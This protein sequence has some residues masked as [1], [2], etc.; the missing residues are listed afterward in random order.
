MVTGCLVSC[1]TATFSPLARTKE[2]FDARA[3]YL[4][5]NTPS[6]GPPRFLERE[7]SS[8]E[9]RVD[10]PAQAGHAHDG[11]GAG[12]GVSPEDAESPEGKTLDTLGHFFTLVHGA[13]AHIIARPATVP[14][15]QGTLHY[16]PPFPP[17]SRR[18]PLSLPASDWGFLGSPKPTGHGRRHVAGCL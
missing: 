17:F 3:S 7:P 10:T 8:P 9:P 2:P 18:P 5:C 14:A 6:Q 16:L 4:H 1:L 13:L 15:E 12:A 11:A